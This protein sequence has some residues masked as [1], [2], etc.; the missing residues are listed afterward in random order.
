MA[1]PS[2][3]ALPGGNPAGGFWR[4]GQTGEGASSESS[5]FSSEEREGLCWA[6]IET[7]GGILGSKEMKPLYVR[8]HSGLKESSVCALC[9]VTLDLTCRPWNLGSRCEAPRVNEPLSCRSWHPPL[10]PPTPAP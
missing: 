8:Q 1:W 9:D 7:R 4:L 5:E 3:A 10:T 6:Q 2:W